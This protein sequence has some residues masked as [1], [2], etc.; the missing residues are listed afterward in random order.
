MAQKA[1]FAVLT[2]VARLLGYMGDCPKYLE[3]EPS[4]RVEVEPWASTVRT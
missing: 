1:L 4:E 2:P 3:G